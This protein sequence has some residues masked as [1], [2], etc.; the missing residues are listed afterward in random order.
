MNLSLNA[1]LPLAVAPA[2][3]AISRAAPIRIVDER[4]GDFD[5]REALLDEAFGPQRFEK[6]SARLRD[7]RTPARGL[8]L[9]ASDQGALVGARCAAGMSWPVGAPRFSSARLLSPDRIARSGSAP[10]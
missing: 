6:A 5:A 2:G 10:G 3:P 8:A 1:P 9:A 7:G 4:S